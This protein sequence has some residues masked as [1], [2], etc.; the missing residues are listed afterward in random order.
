MFVKENL[1][2]VCLHYDDL[3]DNMKDLLPL[4]ESG[5]PVVGDTVLTGIDVGHD[6]FSINKIPGT[7]FLKLL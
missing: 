3:T 5:L 4:E 1:W 6:L 2:I 7:R